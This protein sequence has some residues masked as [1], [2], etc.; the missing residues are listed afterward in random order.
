MEDKIVDRMRFT[1]R[2]GNYRLIIH[3]Q[4]DLLTGFEHGI[5]ALA[6]SGVD[7]PLF[8]ICLA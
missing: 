4:V 5:R 8:P 1:H 6:V 3:L 7:V 2:H